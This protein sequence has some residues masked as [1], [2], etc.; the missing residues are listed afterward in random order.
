MAAFRKAG[1]EVLIV[2]PSFYAKAR[3]G[4]Q[5]RLVAVMRQ[6]LPAWLGELIEFAYNF[7]AYWHLHRASRKFRPDLIYERYN[8]F[9][10][11][12]AWY[13]QRHRLLFYMEVNSPLA[14]ERARFGG[15]RA[16]RFAQWVEHFAWR[17][18][19]RVLAVTSTLRETIIAVGVSPER[20][21]VVPN[22]I[23]LECY[24]NLPTNSSVANQ[25]V[26][27]FVGFVRSWHGLDSVI[28][29]MGN[30]DHRIHLLVVGDGPARAA[31]E[32]KAA[33][34]GLVNRVRFTGLAPVTDIPS[35]VAGFDIA[36]QPKAV[37]YAS[38][39]KIFDYMAAGR[40][41][42]APDQPNIR[43]ILVNE[44]TALLFDPEDAGAMW[45]AVCRLAEDPGLRKRLGEAARREI[46]E[47]D[48][49][50]SHNAR[51]IA[52]LADHDLG[53]ISRRNNAYK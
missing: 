45:R 12:G 3:F 6:L 19:D 9:Y 22:G 30:A 35:L 43:E 34:L 52:G 20:V 17:A 44:D 40:A 29:A 15:L 7:P 53:K 46:L 33:D 42:V 16:R 4:G 8:L 48:Y 32:R 36:L 1:H 13:A 28:A 38:P 14:A 41:I 50:W 18:A 39:L 11:A 31:L 25:I 24:A 26:L 10:L 21:H 23:D 37:A 47:R 5:S 27:G 2:G 51:L 49:T